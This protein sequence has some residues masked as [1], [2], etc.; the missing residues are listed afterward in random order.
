MRPDLI[1]YDRA[2]RKVAVIEVKNRRGTSCTW[3][4]ELRKNMLSY[5]QD[6]FAR[7]LLIATADRLYLWKD[8]HSTS[9]IPPDYEAQADSIFAPYIQ[10]SRLDPSTIS[11]HAFELIVASW[12]TELVLGL[13]NQ[14]LDWASSGFYEAI[15]NGRVDYQVAA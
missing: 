14:P 2:G 10:R 9:L 4:A 3:A 12:L 1:I 6:R 11:G 5:D 13:S 8:R 15:R 7:Y